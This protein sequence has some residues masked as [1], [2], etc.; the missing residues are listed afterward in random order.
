MFFALA[1][2][3]VICCC[4]FSY[5]EAVR[6]KI[7]IYCFFLDLA[8]VSSLLSLLP[9]SSVY[10]SNTIIPSLIGLKTLEDGCARV[11]GTSSKSYILLTH[12]SRDIT[13]A[14][15]SLFCRSK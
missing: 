9:S 1:P 13:C 11:P 2:H 4:D 10:F 8:F 7:G 12:R 6:E 3:A 15:K 5:N 14:A